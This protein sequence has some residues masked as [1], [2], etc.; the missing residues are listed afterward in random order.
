MHISQASYIP[1]CDYLDAHSAQ[2]FSK[3][4]PRHAN[5]YTPHHPHPRLPG[6]GRTTATAPG[7]SAPPALRQSAQCGRAWTWPPPWGSRPPPK[8]SPSP[9]GKQNTSSRGSR[10]VENHT[11]VQAGRA[12]FANRISDVHNLKCPSMSVHQR[13]GAW[14]STDRMLSRHAKGR[15]PLAPSLPAPARIG[16]GIIFMVT[17]APETVLTKRSFPNTIRP[18]SFYL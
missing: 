6:P 8:S 15:G 12:P 3:T 13:E 17:Q 4:R 5:M 9:P 11:P 18:C 7:S 10:T 14:T 16:Q 2:K 1:T